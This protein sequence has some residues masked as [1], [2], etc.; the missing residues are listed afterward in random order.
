MDNF[1]KALEYRLAGYV[2]ENVYLWTGGMIGTYF[3]KDDEGRNVT[4]FTFA[5]VS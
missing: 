1:K 3:L 5:S 4:M 2:K